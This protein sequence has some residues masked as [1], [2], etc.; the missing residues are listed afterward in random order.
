[1]TAINKEHGDAL[2]QLQQTIDQGIEQ[3]P[4]KSSAEMAK[5]FIAPMFQAVADSTAVVA[6]AD[7]RPEGVLLH[8]E[9]E[10][11]ADSKTSAT[12]KEWK[13][14]PLADLHK[15]PAGQMAYD[16]MAYTPALMK[17]LMPL[18]YG[19]T[20]GSD[21]EEDKAVLK[22]IGELADAGPRVRLDAMNVPLSGL[23][24]WKYDDPRKAVAAQL[25]LFKGLKAGSSYG[26]V[27]KANPVVKAGAEKHGGFEFHAVSLKW[28]LDKMLEKQGAA[29]NDA[30][31]QMMTEYFKAMLGEGMDLWFGTDGK[32]VL[33]VMA[34]DWPAARALVDRYQKGTDTLGEAQPFKD[35][36]KH[37]PAEGSML[38]LM[39]VPKYAEIIAK[40][41]VGIVKQS[42]LPL[43]LPPDFEKPAVK[44]QTSYLGMGLTLGPGRGGFD[45]WLS[46]TSVHDVYKMYLERLL[47]RKDF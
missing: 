36:A 10:V 14:I 3:S 38:M 27:L 20:A 2:K 22:A 47:T 31:K 5:R 34:K 13:S 25:K 21:S 43:Q 28:D 9:L 33:Q 41:G 32:T 40:V 6:S 29:L 46:A 35:A 26:S 15:L 30:Q 19:M 44:G 16:G 8:V 18:Q 12:L 1:M 4:D 42:G 7:L 24:V 17:E 23:Q 37:L 39:D 11:A 45:L